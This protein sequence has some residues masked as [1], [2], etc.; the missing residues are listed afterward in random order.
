MNDT[1]CCTQ[2][3]SF[4]QYYYASILV[5]L[6][7]LLLRLPAS[8][9]SQQTNRRNKKKTF[10]FGKF[11]FSWLSLSF[12][13]VTYYSIYV[14]YVFICYVYRTYGAIVHWY[15]LSQSFQNLFF[16]NK[17]SH[18]LHSW[19]FIWFLLEGSQPNLSG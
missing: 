3:A 14:F 4:I 5:M 19:V 10:F 8:A 18:S 13:H 15:R 1:L 7:V 17:V 9:T 6:T 2:I 12:R 16:Y 11:I